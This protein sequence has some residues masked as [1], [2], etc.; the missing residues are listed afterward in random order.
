M[1]LD[2]RHPASL[3]PR[4]LHN[5]YLV[6]LMR[7]PVSMEMISYIAHQASRAIMIS[8]QLPAPS[9]LPTPPT[10]PVKAPFSE[11]QNITPPAQVTPKLPSL[12][13][14]I[15]RLVNRSNVQVPTLLTTLIYLHRVRVKVPAMTKGRPCTRHRV[16]LATLIV[17]AKYLNDSSPKNTHWA[18][19]AEHFDLP[20]VNLM[21]EQLLY[22]LGYDLRFDEQEAC[23]HFAPFIP[24]RIV[25]PLTPQQQETRAA[26]VERV[27]KAGKARAQ[28]QL[29]TPPSEVPLQPPIGSSIVSTVR[30]IA[31]RL[32]S[33]RLGGAH[34]RS[35]C[36]ASPISSVHSC[37]S[38][39]ATDS[40]MESLM[41]DSG[42][43]SDSASSVSDDEPDA[44]EKPNVVRKPFVLG[45][46]PP[47]AHREGRKVSAA[48]SVRSIATVRA[49]DSPSPQ[50]PPAPLDICAIRVVNRAAG[51]RASSY[52][53]G[54]SNVNRNQSDADSAGGSGIPASSM[55]ASVSMSSNGFL[56]RMWSAAIKGQEKEKP[57][58]DLS[59]KGSMGPSVVSVAEPVER[60]PPVH[61][62]NAFHR[63]VHSKSAIFRATANQNLLDV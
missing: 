20:E 11:T 23:I 40:E 22:I 1:S 8:E 43:S 17:A 16:F 47:Q 25:C 7:R 18:A 34:G 48:G 46:I 32:S 5:P 44:D 50:N 26:A 53:Y 54:T 4:S 39:S 45:G 31:R 30:G 37:D 42:F 6:E 38:S 62:A 49:G 27:S 59:G 12:V 28:A 19:Y 35:S 2:R 24:T 14:F 60:N 55:K 57:T 21:E 36:I 3:L 29:P 51:K 33:S 13:N 56:S 52:V 41:E 61:G 63:L 9:A 10:T 58:C 15:M